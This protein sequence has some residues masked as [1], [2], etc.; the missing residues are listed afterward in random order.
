MEY[1][2]ITFHRDGSIYPNLRGEC[3]LFPSKEERNWRDCVYT[4]NFNFKCCNDDSE[5]VVISTETRGNGIPANRV[6]ELS[7]YAEM[8]EDY[9]NSINSQ[10]II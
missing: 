4:R 7:R 10:V 2:Y 9:V 1:K 5:V 3:L 6:S 8:Y